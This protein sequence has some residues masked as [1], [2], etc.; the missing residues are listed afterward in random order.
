VL[1]LKPR[2]E[3]EPDALRDYVKARVAAYKYPRVVSIVDELPKGATSDLDPGGPQRPAGAT[4][5]IAFVIPPAPGN[6]VTA[7]NAALL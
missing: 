4:T 6:P 3:V 2:A 7:S 5:L 1:S